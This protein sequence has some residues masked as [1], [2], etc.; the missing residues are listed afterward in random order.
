MGAA[1][2]GGSTASTDRKNRSL[3]LANDSFGSGLVLVFERPIQV[4]DFVEVGEYQ[5][6]VERIGAR[7]TDS[8]AANRDSFS[9]TGSAFTFEQVG[10]FATDRASFKAPA[11][12]N[13][14]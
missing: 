1:N 13:A 2:L 3:F 4:G 6:V 10:T 11:R 8:A 14:P 9:S 5:G 7:S 12:T